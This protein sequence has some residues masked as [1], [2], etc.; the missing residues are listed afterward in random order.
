MCTGGIVLKQ[1][2]LSLPIALQWKHWSKALMRRME[3]K[4]T[5][6]KENVLFGS[7]VIFKRF[8]WPPMHL[9]FRCFLLPLCKL[10]VFVT[11]Q[12]PLKHGATG[13][14]CWFHVWAMRL[15]IRLKTEQLA[16]ILHSALLQSIKSSFQAWAQ[17]SD[18]TASS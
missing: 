14:H 8:S 15:V 12:L 3:V 17:I 10:P 16:L 11:E 5:S 7:T 18:I 9:S 6:Q 2:V 4:T 1:K 13:W